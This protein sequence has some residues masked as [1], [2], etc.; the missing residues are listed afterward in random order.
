MAHIRVSRKRRTGSQ[1]T[2]Q[3]DVQ[4]VVGLRYRL[5]DRRTLWLG[6]KFLPHRPNLPDSDQIRF[7]CVP[8]EMLIILN[9]VV[10]K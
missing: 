7:F 9:R 2:T 4:R 5:I 3:Q 8:R 6:G 1:Q 10:L